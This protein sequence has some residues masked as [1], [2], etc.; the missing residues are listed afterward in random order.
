MLSKMIKAPG[1]GNSAFIQ[2]RVSPGW[3]NGN[4]RQAG[5]GSKER[6]ILQTAGKE[7]L[8]SLVQESGRLLNAAN[9]ALAVYD[10]SAGDL[11]FLLIL[12]QGQREQPFAIKFSNDLGLV[13]HVLNS[14]A[15][16]LIQDLSE[17]GIAVETYPIC[18]TRPIRSWLSVPVCSPAPAREKAQGVIIVWSLRPNAFGERDLQRLSALGDQAATVIRDARWRL[19]DDAP[20]E[21]DRNIQAG[22]RIRKELARDLH[23][24]PIQLVSAIAMRL[25]LCRKI[26]DQNPSLLPEQISC[27]DELARRAIYQM[28][29][30]LLELRPIVLET[31]GLGAALRVLVERWQGLVPTTRLTLEVQS[32]HPGDKITRQEMRVEAAI[33]AIVQE[34]VNNALKHAQAGHVEVRVRETPA[35]IHIAVSDDGAGFDMDAIIRGYEQRGSLGLIN[36]RERS[37]LIGAELDIKSVPGQGTRIAISVHKAAA[38]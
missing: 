14:Q 3:T 23:D 27:L 6:V 7:T 18:S 28:R 34:A 2:A 13:G 25:D 9:F 5:S 26:M 30:M 38:D 37:E 24:G 8:W 29:T 33:L 11:V 21:L 19:A 31:H 12:R 20:D 17:T 22:E 32:C 16:L 1:A 36:I 4:S 15:P 35:A 10:D